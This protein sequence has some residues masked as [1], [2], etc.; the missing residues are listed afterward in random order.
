MNS[1]CSRIFVFVLAVLFSSV[2]S[3][4]VSDKFASI[5]ELLL[6][7]LVASI[8]SFFLA[9]WHT[10][11]AVIGIAVGMVM[12]SGISLLWYDEH[13]GEALLAEQGIKYFFTLGLSGLAVV[14]SSVVGA[15]MRVRRNRTSEIRY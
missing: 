14:A 4:E 11:L 15:F 5:P 10:W 1:S 12:F 2:A 6:Q 8:I 7:S 3:A 9:R 13:M